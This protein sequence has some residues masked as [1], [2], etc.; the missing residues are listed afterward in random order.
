MRRE[1]IRSLDLVQRW[2]QAVM[3]HAGG[4]EAGISAPE[5]QQLIK[6]H[7]HEADRVIQRSEKLTALERISIYS[8]AYYARL[9]ECL[10]GCFPILKQS[11]GDDVFDSFAIE[12]LQQYPSRSYTLDH[13]GDRFCDFLRETRPA[14]EDGGAGGW[15]DFLIDLALLEWTIGKVFDGPGTEGQNLLTPGML[16][17]FPADRF[18]EAKLAPVAGFTLLAFS[19]PVSTYYTAVRR[20]A[21]SESLPFPDPMREYVAVFRRDYVVRRYQLAESQYALLQQIQAGGAVGDALAA[22]ASIMNLDDDSL[23]G[24]FQSWFHLW[25]R[26]G[27]FATITLNSR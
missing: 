5:A 15:P 27:F 3:T 23:A 9:L 4:A 16:Q 24:T 12:Y 19:Y 21:E 1:G 6:L 17:E 2:F 13:L 11:L 18:A 22:A 10:G 8:N 14:P 20:A 25:S 7:P 26:E